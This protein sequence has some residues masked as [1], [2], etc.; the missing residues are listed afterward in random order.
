MK[1]AREDVLLIGFS[2][3]QKPLEER[4]T[5]RELLRE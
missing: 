4:K 5:K 1:I 2:F 3:R